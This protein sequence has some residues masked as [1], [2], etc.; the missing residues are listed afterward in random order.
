MIGV[1][2]GDGSCGGGGSVVIWKRQRVMKYLDNKCR[3]IV[4]ITVIGNKMSE[5]KV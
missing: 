4:I 2:D 3:L 5:L 1:G